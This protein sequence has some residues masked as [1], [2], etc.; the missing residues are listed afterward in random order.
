MKTLKRCIEPCAF[1]RNHCPLTE[2]LGSHLK[3][4]STH[5]CHALS[6]VHNSQ[7][8]DGQETDIEKALWYLSRSR[9]VGPTRNTF[10]EEMVHSAIPVV[11]SDLW[12]PEPSPAPP[13]PTGHVLKVLSKLIILRNPHVIVIHHGNTTHAPWCCVSLQHTVQ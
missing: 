7:R 1:E 9:E 10:H 2:Q 11:H 4:F 13:G 6:I 5:E 8:R 12:H 3:I